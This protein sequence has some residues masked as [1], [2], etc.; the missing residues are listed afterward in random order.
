MRNLF[1]LFLCIFLLTS[2]IDIYELTNGFSYKIYTDPSSKEIA[3]AIHDNDTT[4]VLK[5]LKK[6][7]STINKQEDKYGTSVLFYAVFHNKIDMVRI[8]LEHGADPNVYSRYDS[9]EHVG[10][11]PVHIASQMSEISPEVLAL[12]LSYGGNPNA[13]KKGF[14][15]YQDGSFRQHGLPIN[16]ACG[17]CVANYDK[18]KL[19]LDYGA[20]QDINDIYCALE[21]CIL[22]KR[23]DILL[24]LLERGA[25]YEMTWIHGGPHVQVNVCEA[26]KWILFDPNDSQYQYKLKVIEWL[27]NKGYDYN[28]SP[29]P[30]FMINRIQKKYPDN[31]EKILEIY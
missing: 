18:V 23:M 19:L 12:L 29:T 30:K 31:W 4:K 27:K 24:L 26:L 20:E 28:Q 2:C 15:K 1:L 10:Q 13:D 16:D 7:S 21:Q 5:I 17:V 3:K 25:P 6:D 9:I 8:L 22:S 14:H 11:T